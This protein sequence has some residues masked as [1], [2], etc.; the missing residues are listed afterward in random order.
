MGRPLHADRS[1][2]AH[3]FPIA[4][5]RN[6]SNSF[7]EILN[8]RACRCFPWMTVII[9]QYL[10][11]KLAIISGSRKRICE[12][13]DIEAKDFKDIKDI[14][15]EGVIGAIA[16]SDKFLLHCHECRFRHSGNNGNPCNKCARKAK[17]E[18]P[19]YYKRDQRFPHSETIECPHCH[20]LSL[21]RIS[22]SGSGYAWKDEI[23]C[24]N[25]Q[26]HWEGI[27]REIMNFW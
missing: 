10:C 25:P 22:H 19:E 23:L 27:L 12:A 15:E 13:K 17:S 16:N 2:S 21:D 8:W 6:F 26:C 3:P 1:I 20:Q 4:V 9:S 18:K 14:K 11:M 7:E 24:T 5:S